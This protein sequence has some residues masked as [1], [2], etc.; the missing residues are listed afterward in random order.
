MS[1]SLANSFNPVAS[2]LSRAAIWSIKAPVPPA[3]LPFILWSISFLRKV[4]L[5][6]SPPNSMATSVSGI[7][8]S[9]AFIQAI[10]SCTNSI[11][12]Q[13]AIP[14]P[15]EPVIFILKLISSPYFSFINLKKSSNIDFVVSLTFDR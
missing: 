13:L 5:A 1:Y 10:T 14:I 2:V 15:L 11:P 7:I 8:T 6:S 12:I 4:I 3:Q 9:I